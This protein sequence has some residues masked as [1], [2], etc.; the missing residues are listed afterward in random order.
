MPLSRAAE[1]CLVGFSASG[2]DIA[3]EISHFAKEV[4]VA[5]RY[6][7]D[8]VGK[9]ALY[10]NVWIHAEVHNS[11]LSYLLSNTFLLYEVKWHAKLNKT[12]CIEH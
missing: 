12:V 7:K 8:R 5:E 6:S 10:Q 4:H 1:C 9:I 2:I 11:E 3:L